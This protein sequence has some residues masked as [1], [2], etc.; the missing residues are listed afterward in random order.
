VV[1]FTLAPPPAA[2]SGAWKMRMRTLAE[3][4]R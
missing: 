4:L 2:V 3:T 1:R